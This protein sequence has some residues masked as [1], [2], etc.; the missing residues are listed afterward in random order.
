MKKGKKLF[1]MKHTVGKRPG[2]KTSRASE[3]CETMSINLTCMQLSSQKKTQET[4]TGTN[5][6]EDVRN[7]IK[8]INPI[9][10]RN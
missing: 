2:K 3:I 10:A 1:K 9:E 8:T 5:V 4:G 7:W 6:G